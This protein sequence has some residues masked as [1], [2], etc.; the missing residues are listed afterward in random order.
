MWVWFFTVTTKLLG[1]K[2]VKSHTCTNTHTQM[3][4]G[5]NLWAWKG[6]KCWLP[7]FQ[8]VSQNKR[9]LSDHSNHSS[10][11][12]DKDGNTKGNLTTVCVLHE[13]KYTWKMSETE[14]GRWLTPNKGILH[15]FPIFRGHF[16]GLYGPTGTTSPQLNS[17]G[18]LLCSLRA[19][20]WGPCQEVKRE[21]SGLWGNGQPLEIQ[22]KSEMYS[23]E[24]A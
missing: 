2:A 20:L 11:L 12:L 6:N 1:Y 14:R 19:K 24:R 9:W 18:C 21:K 23:E 5:S 22:S 16:I 4:T 7:L 3:V 8:Q 15:F 17:L 10:R 13:R